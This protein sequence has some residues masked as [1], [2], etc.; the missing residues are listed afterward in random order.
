M[1]KFSVILYLFSEFCT[2]DF[3]M[4]KVYF[5]SMLASPEGLKKKKKK[6][7]NYLIFPIPS[8]KEIITPYDSVSNKVEKNCVWL[9]LSFRTSSN[10]SDVC[11]D[12][13]THAHEGVETLK[14]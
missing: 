2:L 13:S 6:Q 7:N 11:V 8:I 10:Y 4:F 9:V 3:Q 14:F 12:V 5:S 1:I